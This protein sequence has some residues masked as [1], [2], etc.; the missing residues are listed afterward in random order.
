MN[1]LRGR[2]ISDAMLARFEIETDQSVRATIA[3]FD[4]FENNAYP[5]LLS[6]FE[7]DPDPT[8]R[9]RCAFLLE[10]FPAA[11]P[12]LAQAV[13]NADQTVWRSATMSLGRV[14]TRA[15]LPALLKAAANRDS[16]W[17]RRELERAIMD[18]AIKSAYADHEPAED[19][20]AQVQKRIDELA[21]DPITA[22]HLVACKESFNAL[23]LFG[24]MLYTWAMRPDGSVLRFDRDAVGNRIEEETN[25]I[26]LFSVIAFGASH[27][28][29]L[30][31]LIPQPPKSI[32]LCPDCMGK[33][34][35]DDADPTHCSNCDGVGWTGEP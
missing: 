30:V 12:N 19:H 24:N 27:Y 10:R 17:F 20:S 8:I 32:R 26:A 35:I 9:T 6:L 11:A 1:R 23:P 13:A 3:L 25:P 16:K 7:G 2:E 14:G 34:W 28:P 31:P 18:I 4:G 5:L 22:W 29:E 21:P 15:E 33:G